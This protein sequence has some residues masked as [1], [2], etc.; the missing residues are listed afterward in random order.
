MAP[1]ESPRPK[2][3]ERSHRHHHDKRRSQGTPRRSRHEAPSSTGDSQA[4]SADTLAK[5]NLLNDRGGSRPQE[6]TPKKTKRK[7]PREVVNEKIVI[8]KSRKQHKKK[9]RRVVSGALLE[10]G[11]SKRL[12]GL[13]GGDGSYENEYRDDGSRKKKLC[14]W[15]SG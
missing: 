15:I 1:R 11:N 13:R 10:E 4:L 6:V 3:R 9:K 12:R 5:L 14:R 2:P 8:E 7:R